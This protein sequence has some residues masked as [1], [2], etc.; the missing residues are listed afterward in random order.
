MR[1]S[2]W[3]RDWLRTGIRLFDTQEGVLLLGERIND[4]TMDALEAAAE[5]LGLDWRA[6]RPRE[7]APRRD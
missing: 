5:L 2:V 7:Y 3:Y 4:L 6:M 1:P